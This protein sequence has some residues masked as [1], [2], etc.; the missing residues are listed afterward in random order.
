MSGKE[1]NQWPVLVVAAVIR[2]GEHFLIC[3]RPIHK[4]HGGLWEFPGGKMNPGESI[5]AALRREIIEELGVDVI[6]TGALLFVGQEPASDFEIHFVE[7]IISGEPRPLEHE[8]FEWTL[9]NQFETYAMAP[10]D[11]KFA[12]KLSN[13]YNKRKPLQYSSQD[14]KP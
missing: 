7:V 4:S 3:K 14:S 10:M 5:E 11:L 13:E 6:S 2:K 1:K 9:P 8:R 12:E